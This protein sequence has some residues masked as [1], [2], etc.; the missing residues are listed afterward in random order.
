MV[1]NKLADLDI[2]KGAQQDNQPPILVGPTLKNNL[3]NHRPMF[4]CLDFC[5]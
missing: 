2:K 3:S 5:K 4:G 1:F